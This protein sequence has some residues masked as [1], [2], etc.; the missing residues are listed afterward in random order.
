VRIWRR[1]RDLL[2]PM[3][4]LGYWTDHPTEA[5]CPLPSRWPHEVPELECSCGWYAARDLGVILDLDHAPGEWLAPGPYRSGTFVLGPVKGWGKVIPHELGWRAQYAKPLGFYELTIP[6][7]PSY[8]D[9]PLWVGYGDRVVWKTRTS[10]P[11]TAL[12]E[13]YGVPR[14]VPPSDLRR[15]LWPG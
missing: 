7:P 8:A 10:S 3:N 1:I 5:T 2:V 15:R 4:G 6:P 14:L 11:L 13:R 9:P 12:A